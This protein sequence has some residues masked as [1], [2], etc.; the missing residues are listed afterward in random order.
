M[1][2][3]ELTDSELHLVKSA[4]H[5]FLADFGHDESDVLR[6]IKHLL[7]KLASAE[8]ARTAQ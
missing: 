3:I 6:Q 7:A 2:A 1:T 5:S 8:K 4:L